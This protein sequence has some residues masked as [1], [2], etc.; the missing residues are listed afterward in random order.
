[1]RISSKVGVSNFATLSSPQLM[2]MS[3]KGKSLLRL[4]GLLVHGKSV[5]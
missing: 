2:K 1:M 4:S 5:S 3:V